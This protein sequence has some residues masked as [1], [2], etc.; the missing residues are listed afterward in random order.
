[1]RSGRVDLAIVGADRIA[2]NGDVANKVGTYPLAVLARHHEVPFYVVAPVSTVDLATPTGGAIPIEDTRPRGGHIAA[3]ARRRRA[4]HAGGEPGVRR[5]A[6][7]ARH[8]AASSMACSARRTGR[9][10]G[11]CIDPRRGVTGATRSARGSS[12]SPRPSGARSSCAARTGIRTRSRSSAP[13]RSPSPVGCRATSR[14]RRLHSTSHPIATSSC[15]SSSWSPTSSPGGTGSS[16]IWRS[17]GTPPSTQAAVGSRSLATCGAPRPI[18]VDRTV[19]LGDR[20]TAARSSAA[21]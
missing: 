21:A 3:R 2:A 19:A 18:R 17:M 8:G 4:G 7:R 6:R 20:A 11:V 15:R 5:H 10:C 12:G 14:P 13:G 16:S 1:M 9:R